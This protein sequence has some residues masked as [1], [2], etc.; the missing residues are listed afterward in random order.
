M[1]WH[2]CGSIRIATTREEVDW[3]H[4]VQTIADTV[5]FRMQVLGP[6]EIRAINPFV[7]TAGV[8]A[9]AWTLDD[10]HVDPA[11]CCNALAIGAKQMGAQIILRNRVI[12]INALP[13]GEWQ[14]VTEQGVITCEHVV[15]TGGCYANVVGKMVGVSVPI[16]N[17]LHEYIVTE[18]IEEFVARDEEI[19]V[20]R[21]PYTRT[22]YRQEQKSGLIG[23]Y[24][25][26]CEEAWADLCKRRHQECGARRDPTFTGR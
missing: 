16:T 2:G 4:H 5:G 14:V 23:I 21:D 12:D 11:G 26:D 20:M 17:M 18:A 24:E 15:N 13:S 7:T 19:P 1:G 10:G 22:Y 8:L 6:D 3:F 9:G 25:P